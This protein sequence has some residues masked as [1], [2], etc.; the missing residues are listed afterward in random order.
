MGLIISL[1]ILWIGPLLGIFIQRRFNNTSQRVI[2]NTVLFSG[3]F[4]LGISLF[5]LMPELFDNIQKA[6]L[7][8]VAGFLFQ[9]LLEKFTGGLGHGH[10]HSHDIPKSVFVLFGGLMLH[11][12]FEGYSA[13]L[14]NH[15]KSG[16]V[17]GMVVG[18]AIHEIPAAFSLSVL[19]HTRYKGK[20]SA[21]LLLFMYALAT[22]I[23]FISGV[24]VHDEGLLSESMSQVITAIIAGTFLHISTTIVFENSLR[25]KE[26]LSKW[27]VILSGLAVSYFACLIG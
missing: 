27:I 7:W 18:I 9:I 17:S 21:I 2:S 1:F 12:L 11:A 4:L 19:M 13:G 24:M 14:N 15:I 16:V 10:I 26:G 20:A 6:G 23:G 5:G 25:K 22:P 3:S 8:I